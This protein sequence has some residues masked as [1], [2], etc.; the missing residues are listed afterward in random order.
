MQERIGFLNHMRGL[1]RAWFDEGLAVLVAGDSRYFNSGRS[2]AERCY[3]TPDFELPATPIGWDEA[4]GTRPWI[5]TKATCEVMKWMGRNGGKDG[6]VAAIARVG[7][8]QPF[9]P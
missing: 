1:F 2:A 4:A 5:Y 9:D 8:G 6:V 3:G 7:A